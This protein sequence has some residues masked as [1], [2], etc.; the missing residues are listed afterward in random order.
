MSKFESPKGIERRFATSLR[1]IAR[2]VGMLIKVSTDG[3]TIRNP[4]QMMEQ[5]TKY[6]ESLTPWSE[7]IV[8]E[9]IESV[10]RRNKRAFMGE[11]K[12]LAQALRDEFRLSGLGL[13]AKQLQ[14]EQVNLIKSLPIEAGL[15]AQKLSQEAAMNGARAPEIAKQIA[16]T[17]GIT[18][19]R[20]TLIARTETAKANAAFTQARAQYVGATHYIWRTARDGDVREQHSELDGEVFR[21]DQPPYIEGE[22]NHNPG[23]IWNCRCFA[24]VI[25]PGRERED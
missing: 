1:Q 14:T 5:L 24:E 8:N 12:E 18:L 20:A 23:E 4:A 16:E 3:A 19:R 7:R 11:S 17:E 22:G 2:A 21:F 15:R 9:M 13:V 25:L 10:S 6:S